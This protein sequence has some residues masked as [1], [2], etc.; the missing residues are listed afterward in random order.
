M[1]EEKSSTTFGRRIIDHCDAQATL[2]ARHV[3]E[4]LNEKGVKKSE[5]ERMIAFLL[6]DELVHFFSNTIRFYLNDPDGL[7]W[8]NRFPAT[9]GGKISGAKRWNKSLKLHFLQWALAENRRNPELS[10]NAIA[11]KYARDN[12]NAS[13]STLR[14]Y[15][16][17]IPIDG[18]D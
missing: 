3:I 6:Q 9:R 7:K 13:V 2:I 12:P 18:N 4:V 16:A 11:A 8:L 1:T 10:K 17:E 14:R 5:R 15:L